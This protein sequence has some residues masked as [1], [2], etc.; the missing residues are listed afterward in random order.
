V[1][2]GS[3]NCEDNSDEAGCPT[4]PPGFRGLSANGTG[5]GCYKVLLTANSWVESKEICVGL[6]ADVNLAVITNKAEDDAVKAYLNSLSSGYG[7]TDR[8]RPITSSYSSGSPSFYTAGRRQRD[9]DCTSSFRWI[10]SGNDLSPLT[11]TAW[12]SGE[13]SCTNTLGM[14][15]ESCLTVAVSSGWNDA[16]CELRMCALCEASPA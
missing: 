5:I 9:G 3:N 2:D 1:C 15:A 14:T 8:C 16:P 10:E 4:C 12:P 11:Y 13:P 7:N 6:G